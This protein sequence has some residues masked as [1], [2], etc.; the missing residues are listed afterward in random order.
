MLPANGAAM[1]LIPGTN[2]AMTR[3]ALSAFVKRF[4]RPEHAGLRIH[5]QPAQKS[6]QGPAG[7]STQPELDHIT[8]SMSA[9]ER[10]QENP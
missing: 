8:R 5:G 4:R 9:D 7:I 1:V 6:E 3:V 2:F 10:R